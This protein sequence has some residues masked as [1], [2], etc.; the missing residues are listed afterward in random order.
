MKTRWKYISFTYQKFIENC[1]FDSGY[2]I[3]NKNNSFEYA[4]YLSRLIW[5]FDPKQ[6]IIEIC[7]DEESQ[8]IISNPIY[9][10]VLLMVPLKKPSEKELEQMNLTQ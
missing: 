2:I 7:I 9:D 10:M 3:F 4:Y 5:L 8:M 1:I 6:A